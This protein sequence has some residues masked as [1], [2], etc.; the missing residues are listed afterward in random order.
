[1]SETTTKQELP[2]LAEAIMRTFR[3]VL[4]DRFVRS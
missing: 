1:M 3:S 4:A 2:R